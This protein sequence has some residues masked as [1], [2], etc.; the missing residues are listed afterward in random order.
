MCKVACGVGIVNAEQLILVV[1]ENGLTMQESVT[2]LGNNLRYFGAF[3]LEIIHHISGFVG[4]RTIL[5]N[6]ETNALPKRINLPIGGDGRLF[7][8]NYDV[9]CLQFDF[10][11]LDLGVTIELYDLF[12][13]VAIDRIPGGIQ[14]SSFN[15][16]FFFLLYRIRLYS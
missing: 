14:N 13:K 9:I 4:G 11:V 15:V 12:F 2:L 6:R 5:E 3:G 8:I 7:V 16:A 10:T 1:L